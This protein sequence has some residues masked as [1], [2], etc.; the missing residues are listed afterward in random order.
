MIR[1]LNRKSVAPALALVSLIFA[2]DAATS[3]TLIRP[4]TVA[5]QQTTPPQPDTPDATNDAAPPR[6]FVATAYALR[7]RTATG[8]QTRRGIIAADRRVLPMGTRVRLSAGSQSGEYVVADTGGAV[9]GNKIDIWVPSNGEAMRFGRR[10]IK[11]T[12]LQYPRGNRA[13]STAAAARKTPRAAR[14][15]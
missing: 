8:Q 10:N 4:R 14:K 12:V 6:D 2:L 9:R 7:G 13:A 11:L 3:Q 1:F 15:R 5:P